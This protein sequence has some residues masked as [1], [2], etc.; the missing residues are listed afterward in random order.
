[1]FTLKGTM[2]T[3]TILTFALFT[4]GFVSSSTSDKFAFDLPKE[5]SL[6]TFNITDPGTSTKFNA[7][8]TDVI[9]EDLNDISLDSLSFDLGGSHLTAI[10]KVPR[11]VITGFHISRGTYL[12]IPFRGQGPF[13]IRVLDS[14]LKLITSVHPDSDGTLKAKTAVTEIES[15][16]VRAY[17]DDLYT[18]R[19]QNP[20]LDDVGSLL[21]KQINLMFYDFMKYHIMTKAT[22]L[23]VDQLN[24]NLV[25]VPS[26][27]MNDKTTLKIDALVSAVREK[28][29]KT[30]LE[31]MEL[32]DMVKNFPLGHMNLTKRSFHGLSTIFRSSHTIANYDWKNESVLLETTL[33]FENLTV[34]NDFD[35]SVIGV[36]PS[37]VSRS[38]VTSA[39]S[40]L[41]VIQPLDH[42]SSPKLE[43]YAINSIDKVWVDISG[44]G[45]W[46]G[47]VET[48]VNAISNAFRSEIAKIASG[49]ISQ[50]L[51]GELNKVHFYKG[52]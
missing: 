5:W 49:P 29:K 32:P 25:K 4:I 30:G 31:P 9:I 2:S 33:G 41:R 50:M 46:S 23:L 40:T 1:M 45:A 17:F 52:E 14:T 7:T 13:K 51:E 15:R 20:V 38:V 37:G 6:D 28:I 34:V 48:I 47:P 16:K 11:M 24:L 36:G 27:I 3:F 35:L 10:F 18:T 26:V 39:T 42:S 21:R 8:Y 19:G 12:F 43:S 44:L 22:P